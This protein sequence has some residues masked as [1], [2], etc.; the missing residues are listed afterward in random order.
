VAPTIRPLTPGEW[1]LLRDIR[2]QALGDAPYAFGSTY[3]EE[4]GYDDDRWINM[5]TRLQWWLAGSGLGIVAALPRDEPQVISMWVAPSQRATGLATRLLHT[6]ER[7]A[8]ARHAGA[9]RL[10][11]SDRNPRARAFYERYGFI[12][13]GDSEPL[14][15]NPAAAAVELRL[16]LRPARLRFAPS[17]IGELHAG[18]VRFAALTSLLARQVSGEYFVR[19]EATD[20]AREVPGAAAA[21]AADLARLG[22]LDGPLHEQRDMTG[23]HRSVLSRLDAHLYDDAGAI[24][25]RT[26]TDGTV[27]WDDLARGRV[28]VNNRDLDD[29]VLVRSDGSPTFFLA[30]T[31]EDVDDGITHAV[32]T[33]PML[34]LSAVQHHIWRALDTAPP[35]V[36][37]VPLVVDARGVPLRVGRTDATVA[38][39]C[40]E[41]GASALVVYMAHPA[42][43]S[44]KVPP[45]S[46]DELVDVIDFARLPRRPFVFDRAALQ[47]LNSRASCRRR[48]VD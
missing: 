32:R 16:A 33:T 15:S 9:L 40:R 31:A 36:G 2:L 5:A 35:R 8:R 46:L 30:S 34:R 11:V 12:A 4:R 17:P 26:P 47:R 10:R 41:V 22:L 38:A 29:P 14:R 1:S 28:T 45:S 3:A 25:F 27:G 42:A 7:W 13:T 48:V 6:V 39:L 44:L 18:H 24:R 43:A 37:H 20:R 21:I 23:V 19:L